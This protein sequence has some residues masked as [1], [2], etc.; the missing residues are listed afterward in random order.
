MVGGPLGSLVVSRRSFGLPAGIAERRLV[1]A[2]SATTLLLWV[3]A[4]AILPLLPSYL[5]RHGSG[6]GLVGVI[7]AAY[8]AASVLTQ[9]PVGRLS[10]RLGR[11]P[12]VLGGLLIFALGSVGFALASAPGWAIC[13]RALQGVGAGAVTVASAAAIGTLVPLFERGAAFGALYGSQMLALALGPLVG[14]VVGATSM[15]ALFLAAAVAAVIAVVPTLRV[16]PPGR[17]TLVGHYEPAVS[18]R[19]DGVDAPLESP[20]AGVPPPASLP[21][22][23]ALL[24]VL[25]VFATA[26]LYGGVYETCWTLLLQLRNA[27]PYEIGLSWTLFALPYALLSVPAGRLANRVDRR[28]LAVVA[29]VWTGAFCVAYPFIHSVPALVGLGCFEALGAVVGTPPALLILT[30]SIPPSAQGRA[31]GAVET[32]RTAALAGA[33]ALAGVL[34]GLDPVIPFALAAALGLAGSALV[35][36]CWRDV[37]GR[38]SSPPGDPLTATLLAAE[39]GSGAPETPGRGVTGA[40]V[41]GT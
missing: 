18:N 8:F 28:L 19:G 9:Y 31:Q 27:H 7:M 40:G 5:R 23:G 36:V 17:A 6:P 11:R 39:R 35:V 37:A 22:S 4:S 41:A 12:V 32:A 2:L 34:F 3:G 24:G 33:A 16:L 30:E 38:S 25:V 14:S 26:G 21:R 10:D 13:F 20:A 29:L 15:R 1:V